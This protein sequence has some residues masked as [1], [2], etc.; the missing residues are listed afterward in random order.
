M[1]LVDVL[2]GVRAVAWVTPVH[3]RKNGLKYQPFSLY[4]I[5]RVGVRRW[6]V[7][8]AGIGSK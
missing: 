3:V 7:E 1:Y 5:R 8:S 2:D 6:L 4:R